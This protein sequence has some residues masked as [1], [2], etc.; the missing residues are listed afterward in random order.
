MKKTV[1]FF[2]SAI[3]LSACSSNTKRVLILIKGD[4]DINANA[5][6][7]TLKG[8]AGTE[9]KSVDFNTKGQLNLKL[10]KEDEE[11]T[12]GIAENG[13]YILNAKNDTVIGSYQKYSA[14][15]NAYD[16]IKQETIKRGIDSLQQLTEGKNI[17]FVNRTYFILP[18]QAAKIS[19][20]IDAIIVAPYHRMTSV[21]KVGDKDPEVYRFYS[22]KEIREKIEQL[23][24]AT[25]AA[26]AK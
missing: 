26:P 13:L 21:E 12:V 10:K 5:K 23:K 2:V 4:A 20:N 14:P 9:E 7:I 24:V 6:T 19:D 8:G 15:K 17:S 22:I 11:S 1:A 18:Y 16:T 25:T 3:V